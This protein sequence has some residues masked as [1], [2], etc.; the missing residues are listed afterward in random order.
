MLQKLYKNIL[1]K[2]VVILPFAIIS[3]TN[4]YVFAAQVNDNGSID[5]TVEIDQ[6]T[7]NGPVLS[8]NEEFGT[9]I[10]DIGDLNDDG[11][12]D[13]LVG[14]P[15]NGDTGEGAVFI[16]YMNTDGSIDSTV[17][18]NG[19][20]ANGAGA[21]INAA[22]YYGVSVAGLG[23]LN[24]DGVEDILVGARIAD[25]GGSTR[26]AAFIH[27]MNTNGSIDSTAVI[28]SNTA[29]GPTL[30][31]S[32]TYG[33]SVANIGDL[34][35]D[36]VIDIAVGATGDDAG[37]TS[38]GALHISFLNTDGSIDSTIEIN[39]LTT[40]GPTLNDIDFYGSAVANIGDVNGD[41]VEDLAVSANGANGTAG[42]NTGAV[43]I[44]FMNTDGSVDSTVEINDTTLNGPD[45]AA[46]DS[47]GVSL[48]SMGDFDGDGI[49]DIIVG[50][51]TN[52]DSGSGSQVG[53][54][55]LSY[56][57]SDGSIKSTVEF[58]E[59]TVNGPSLFAGDQ[60]GIGVANI[61]DLDAD[62]L[63]DIA[64]GARFDDNDGGTHRG[65]VFIHFMSITNNTPT[66]MQIDGGNS[67]TLVENSSSGTV[68]GAL[69]SSDL[70]GGD[71]HTYTLVSGTGSEDNARF[72]IN[73]SNL[74]SNFV[75]DFENPVDTGATA[76]NNTYSIRI[77]TSDGSNAYQ[78]VI[79]ITVTNVNAAPSD[80]AIDSGNSDSIAENSAANTS[81]GTL[82]STDDGEN[83]TATYTYSLACSSAGV[84]DAH[85][86]ISG[87]SLRNTT[88]FDYE[89]PADNDSNN[90]YAI[91]VRVSD[92]DLTYDE[93]LTITV[94]D[95]NSSPSS[96]AIDGSTSDTLITG[97]P[98]NTS[99]GTLTGTDDGEDSSLSFALSC[100]TAGDDDAH[101]NIS[102]TTLRNTTIFDYTSPADTDLDNVYDI[103]VRVSDGS[104]TFDQNLTIT[105]EQ[106]VST[107][108]S[109]EDSNTFHK[110]NRCHAKKP[111]ETTWIKIEKGEESGISGVNVYWTQY[112]ANKVNIKIDDG[113]GLFPWKLE[114][115]PNDGKVFLKNVAQWQK[116]KLKPIND[117]SEGDYGPEL[118]IDLYPNG[119]YNSI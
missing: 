42:N 105:V 48:D 34:N 88:V 50:A 45:L 3:V 25:G 23:D 111:P 41:G 109:S 72:T 24:E 86:N 87:T 71:S 83:N 40:N 98:E 110:D 115:E 114:R 66:D 33:T 1:F 75:P 52:S 18:I 60:Y 64:V 119:W 46:G 99:I 63:N 84:D 101:F 19:A 14:A 92:G 55:H 67:D 112:S 51:Y 95:V 10:A 76:G 70:D 15:R 13:I 12:R 47:Y 103:C 61:S 58:N 38:R 27:F 26:G 118:S 44:H 54:A 102:G 85:F 94:T 106:T 53:A 65:A 39:D 8:D 11:V 97:S 17:E 74:E 68:V 73:G 20:T 113:T 49:E 117:C 56:L 35:G 78:E 31:T 32:D 116:I 80:I 30:T 28:D 57:N 36:D 82:S 7:S 62:G 59:N 69:T 96:V 91:C 43:F 107:E 29:N 21:N 104:N 2:I 4:R 37:G 9:S 100:S 89:S 79:I 77:Q 16:M 90:S 81:I 108:S 22:D 6:A 5:S 93:N